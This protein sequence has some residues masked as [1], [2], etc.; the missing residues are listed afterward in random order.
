MLFIGFRE[1]WVETEIGM[2]SAV[3]LLVGGDQCG[4]QYHS[5]HKD[6]LN[7]LD[8]GSQLYTCI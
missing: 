1:V 8:W 2:A 5:Q 3:Q 6:H 4:L 7:R